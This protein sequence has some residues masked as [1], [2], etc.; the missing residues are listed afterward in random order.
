MIMII[1][2]ASKS[3]KKVEQ[4]VENINE[5]IKTT[6]EKIEHSAAYMSVLGEGFKK[7]MEIAKDSG[8]S[9][10]KKSKVKSKK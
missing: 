1:R 4:V 7:V 2:V 6:K 9:V 10:S 3:V 5:V 8:I